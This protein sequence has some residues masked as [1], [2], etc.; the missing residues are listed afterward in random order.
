MT[1]ALSLGTATDKR[2]LPEMSK[3]VR[4][5]WESLLKRPAPASPVEQNC[6]EIT[7]ERYESLAEIAARHGVSTA[8]LVVTNG[9][10]FHAQLSPGDRLTLPP[11]RE[12]RV[13]EHLAADVTIVRHMVREDDTLRSLASR[14]GA[15]PELVLQAN[16]LADESSLV[17]GMS[18]IMPVR[19]HPVDTGEIPRETRMPA[20]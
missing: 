18:V 14:C 19:L 2:R 11:A 6:T 12:R 9:L 1:Q 10:S 3:S 8:D 16:G 13:S 5:A 20:A 4:R 7:V 17:P 15:S